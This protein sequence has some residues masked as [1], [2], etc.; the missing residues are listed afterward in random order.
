MN[1]AIFKFNFVFKSTLKMK[2]LIIGHNYNTPFGKRKIR[3][4]CIY[5]VR[6]ILGKKNHTL[7]NINT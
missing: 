3:I 4:S 1:L 5:V 7:N 6:Y 2:R